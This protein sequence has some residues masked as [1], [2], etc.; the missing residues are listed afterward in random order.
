MEEKKIFIKET[1]NGY[2]DELKR[3]IT[4][5][6]DELGKGIKD[7]FGYR[8]ANINDDEAE[9][10][11]FL[12]NQGYE[13]TYKEFSDF[14]G[15]CRDI[16]EANELL[17]EEI[18]IEEIDEELDDDE[19]KVVAGGKGWFKKNWKKLAIGAGAALLLGAAIVA[20]GG[21]GGVIVGATAMGAPA[22]FSMLAVAGATAHATLT[23]GC[24]IAGATGAA[25]MIAGGIGNLID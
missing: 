8:I 2:S 15:D 1:V 10:Y 17:I 11:S 9:V 21:I 4:D 13:I 5:I 14:I 7:G 23:T 24:I 25:S 18:S 3:L 20:T 16:L 6:G 22:G 19:L 12:K